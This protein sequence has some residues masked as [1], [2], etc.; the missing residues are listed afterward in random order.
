[1]ET[2]K[3]L[4]ETIGNKKSAELLPED[5]KKELEKETKK[6]EK[7]KDVKL[8]EKKEKELKEK[9]KNLEDDLATNIFSELSI[10]ENM[11]YNDKLNDIINNLYKKYF[12]E[13][14]P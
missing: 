6:L 11:E 1:K 2:K 10:K 8:K 14:M 5:M 12:Y 13:L 4:E 3:L 9:Y 7:I